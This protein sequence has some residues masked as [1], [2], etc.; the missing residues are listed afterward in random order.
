MVVWLHTIHFFPNTCR[1]RP[2]TLQQVALVN[3]VQLVRNTDLNETIHRRLLWM[4]SSENGLQTSEILMHLS[5]YIIFM[6]RF[7]LRGTRY[8]HLVSWEPTSRTRWPLMTL[9]VGC[10]KSNGRLELNFH[11]VLWIIGMTRNLKED[12]GDIALILD[13]G[14]SWGKS[15][16]RGQLRTASS[17]IGSGF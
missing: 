9:F 16:L 5:S 6:S 15:L 4:Q 10:W 11:L 17:E 8:F 3:V 12:V 7:S 13:S 1:C 14:V 2:R